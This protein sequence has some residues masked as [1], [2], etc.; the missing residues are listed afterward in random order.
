MNDNNENQLIK[1][2]HDKLNELLAQGINPFPY[3]YEKKD[4]IE[5]IQEKFSSL[6]TEEES[7]YIAQTAGRLISKRRHGKAGFGNISDGTSNIQIYFKLDFLNEKYDIFKKID[8][9]DFIGVIGKIF[10]TRTGELT[11]V[12]QD[13]ELLSKSL[14]PLPEKFHG[15][16]DVELRYRKRY[17]DLITN[18]E[19]KDVFIK[20][21]QII[22]SIRSYMEKMKFLE[23]ETPIL[24]TIPGGADAKPF[25]THHNALDI[26]LYLRIAPE[27]FLKR[28]IIGG[29][30]RV[31][32]LNRN[33][34][35]EGMDKNHNPE[36]T[37]LES[38]AAYW[39]Y[40]DV[41]DFTEGMIKH[42]IDNIFNGSLT[43]NRDGKEFT[44]KFPFK[45]ISMIDAIKEKANIDVMTQSEE[46]L[47]KTVVAL[48]KV[49]PVSKGKAIEKLFEH[50]VEPK[51]FEPTFV[52]DF[53]KESSPLT[54]DHR[55][56]KDI[57]ERFELYIAGMELANAYSELNNPIEQKERFKLQESYR[58]QGDDEAQRLDEDF[59]EALEYGMPPTGGL[60]IGIDRLV[61]ILTNAQSI[62]DVILFPT[63][64]E[65]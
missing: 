3:K 65:D 51:L 34:R 30:E 45:R 17:L 54:K 4:N 20:R 58:E 6:E 16:K 44:F 15:L 46:E 42:V 62:R 23:V 11:I 36:F 13:I 48:G 10:K 57:V 5:D 7:D 22:K 14:R 64:K 31:F 9:G 52:I 49:R 63:M 2:R 27:L 60:G 26:D 24:Q 32:E 35:N 19:V 33:F 40:N 56:K 29:F 1:V 50:Y 43:V 21:S 55:E 47:I 25:T 28:L 12:A 59:I 41:M 18:S 39:D 38:Y 37:M 53:P 61:M 8:I